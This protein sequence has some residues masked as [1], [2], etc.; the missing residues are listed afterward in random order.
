MEIRPRQ[1]TRRR[2][3]V[4]SKLAKRNPESL[5]QAPGLQHSSIAN[6]KER[7]ADDVCV[8]GDASKVDVGMH[9]SLECSC[10][11]SRR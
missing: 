7:T 6:N 9:I 11:C 10:Q 4:A 2:S 5:A 1:A 8:C 3:D